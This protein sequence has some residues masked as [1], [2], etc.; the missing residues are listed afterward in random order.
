MKQVKLSEIKKKV[1][2]MDIKW[3]LKL[4]FYS[5]QYS[6]YDYRI[7]GYGRDLLIDIDT[8]AN[9]TAEYRKD[10]CW[11]TIIINGKKDLHITL[12]YH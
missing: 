3:L 1:K 2:D 4:G 10:T 8:K 12:S 6:T 7:Q 11:R 5:V 9:E